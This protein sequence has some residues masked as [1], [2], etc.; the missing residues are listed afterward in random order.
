MP[1]AQF[2]ALQ[3][4]RQTWRDQ[5]V[6]SDKLTIQD[7]DNED[8]LQEDPVPLEAR[9]RQTTIDMF[10][11]VLLFSQGAA[12]ALYDDQ[13]VTTL[14][15]LHDFTNDIIKELC[16]AIRKPGG[17][18]LGHRISKLSMTRLKL[19]AFW[20]RHMWRTSRGVDDWTNTSFEEIKTLTNQKTLKDSL[21]DT[22]PP[23]TLAM[24]LEPHL[25]AK[26]FNDM[27][28]LLGKMHGIAGHP[29]SY[30]LRPNLKGLND[31]DPDDKTKDPPPFGEPGHPYV[32]IDDELCRRAPILCTDLTHLQL[33]ASIETLETEGPFEPSFLADMAPVYNILHS[34]WGK[35]SW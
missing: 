22:K 32:S 29:F 27:L 34:C 10:K 26:A 7:S 3:R 16:H 11:R 30:V 19:F 33:S 23:E 9:I 2:N 6:D 1:C 4:R 17:D 14:D 25:A 24:T 20:A 31:T 21:L 15:V 28:I 5:G 13:M 12:E 18:G 35:L 8:D